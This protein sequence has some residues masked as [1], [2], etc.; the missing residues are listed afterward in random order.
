MRVGALLVLIALMM[1]LFTIRIYKLQSAMTEEAIQEA[2]SI[3]Y[4]TTVPAARGQ[5]LDRNGTVLVTNRASYN[6]A[7]IGYALFNGPT[8]N[9]S[10]LELVRTCQELGIEIEHHLPVS[11]TRP[12][13]YTLDDL[14][15]PWTTYFRW[16]LDKRSIDSDVNAGTFVNNLRRSY[17]LPEDLSDE[18]AYL[19]TAIRYELALRDKDMPLDNYVLAQD[20]TAAQLAAVMELSIPGLVVETSTVREYN[21]KYAAHLLGQTGQMDADEYQKR[22]SKWKHLT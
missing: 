5:I 19:L 10:L 16:F 1:G 11:E 12:Y 22:Y 20:V 18:E 17:N 15:E 13:Q 7:L 4:Y 8:P 9:E 3:Y 21:T 14:G 6:L 2:N